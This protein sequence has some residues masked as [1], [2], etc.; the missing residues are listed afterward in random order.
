MSVETLTSIIKGQGIMF[1]SASERLVLLML[2]ISYVN[3]F[4]SKYQQALACIHQAHQISAQLQNT[5]PRNLDYILAVNLMTAYL[6]LKIKKPQQACE[7]LVI[8]EQTTNQLIA[9]NIC[10]P[11]GFKSID[12]AQRILEQSSN[13][14][15]PLEPIDSVDSEPLLKIDIF[16]TQPGSP[17]FNESGDASKQPSKMSG[18]I[19]LN[20]LLAIA[21]MKSLTFKFNGLSPE[22][23]EKFLGEQISRVKFAEQVIKLKLGI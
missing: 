22:K 10:K 2:V 16:S 19:L 7:F 1:R 5:C 6:L 17:H 14:S 12:E 13:S 21:L 4:H 3:A 18:T 20:S 8:A 23:Q 11:L 9:Q 15:K